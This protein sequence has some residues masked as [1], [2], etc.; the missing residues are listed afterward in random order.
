MRRPSI[1]SLAGGAAGIAAGVIGGIG[2][3]SLSAAGAPAHGPRVAVEGGHVPPVLTL[4]GEAVRL[5][6][7]I[8]CNPR[9]DGE[10]AT[11]PARCMRTGLFS[12]SR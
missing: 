7:A 6:Y 9:D 8:A 1:R 11:A 12:G 2:L 3:T 4:P 10:P 5:R